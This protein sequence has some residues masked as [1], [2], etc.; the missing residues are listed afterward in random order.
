MTKTAALKSKWLA[1][2]VMVA[3][4]ALLF[5][6]CC[7]FN[8]PPFITSLNLNAEGEITTGWVYTVE[9]DAVDADEDELSYAWT[10]DAGSLSG[11][12]A[13][14]EWTAPDEPGSY[15]I[16]VE[17]SDGSDVATDQIVVWVE[18]P[19]NP[20]VIEG[21]TTNCPRVRPGH[22][23]TITCLASDPDG[24]ELIYEWS[25]ERGSITGEGPEVTWTAPGEYGY[26]SITVTVSD[27][28]DG[29]ATSEISITVCGCGSAC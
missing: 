25:T 20:P 5:G 1:G 3:V 19:N 7:L 17:V 18:M 8:E 28:R 15:T 10:A 23:G 29:Q 24:D 2:I 4:I 22:T 21:L 26:Y 16:S 12:G 6:G 11:E 13:T 14:V 27:G 9:C